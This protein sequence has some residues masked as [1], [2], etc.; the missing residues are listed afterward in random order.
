[1]PKP[2]T[3]ALVSRSLPVVAAV[4]ASISLVACTARW[5]AERPLIGSYQL[6]NPGACESDIERSTLV[7]RGDG[8][9][10]QYVHF[11][12]S[13]DQSVKQGRWSYDE[14]AR[15][16]TF[17]KLLI[18]TQTSL[19]VVPSHPAIIYLKYEPG[20]LL[21]RNVDCWYQHPK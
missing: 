12:N 11:K 17:S 19:P 18:G 8:T 4:L 7:I 13:G 15:R 20:R 2:L 5:W 6:V 14:A 10:D 16:I 3:E 1:M 21:D 9:Y